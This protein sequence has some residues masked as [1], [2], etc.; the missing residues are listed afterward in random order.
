MILRVLEQ[1]ESTRFD[2]ALHFVLLALTC[3]IVKQSGRSFRLATTSSIRYRLFAFHSS[4]LSPFATLRRQQQW[5]W[6]CLVR[7]ASTLSIV[8]PDWHFVCEH[9]SHFLV[10]GPSFR[11]NTGRYPSCP[12]HPI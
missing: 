5:V 7:G 6:R 10:C 4:R 8:G 11:R 1:S 9:S 12:G 2:D 3:R